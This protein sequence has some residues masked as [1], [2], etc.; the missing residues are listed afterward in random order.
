MAIHIK[1][2]FLI[3]IIL[4]LSSQ[5]IFAKKNEMIIYIGLPLTIYI[6]YENMNDT[7]FSGLWHPIS[8]EYIRHITGT[9]GIG[10]QSFLGA[11]GTSEYVNPYEK[12]GLCWPLLGTFQ[13]QFLKTKALSL[14]VIMRA[15]VLFLFVNSF[16]DDPPYTVL[17]FQG[18]FLTGIRIKRA[19][20]MF[21][22][23]TI[24]FR[25]IG[26]RSEIGINWMF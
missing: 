7:T 26:I 6:P 21:G 22:V 20:F 5:N 25:S 10:V 17:L 4:I 24:N 16:S 3:L 14:P 2:I 18:C 8:L 12:S 9:I 19:R 15:G 13:Y 1:I 23:E 11:F